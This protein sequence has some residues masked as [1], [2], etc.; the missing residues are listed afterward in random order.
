MSPTPWSASTPAV[1]VTSELAADVA[2]TNAM[3]GGSLATSTSPR[4]SKLV[5]VAPVSVPATEAALAVLRQEVGGLREDLRGVRATL[6]EELR[7]RHVNKST[8]TDGL[9]GAVAW[10]CE[11]L[12]TRE[13]EAWLLKEEVARRNSGTAAIVPM[14]KRAVTRSLSAPER[15][16][17]S[18]N[19][20]AGTAPAIWDGHV[21]DVSVGSSM[22]A[23]SE[24]GSRAAQERAA[25]TARP[26]TGSSSSRHTEPDNNL[27]YS[28][29]SKRPSWGDSPRSKSS[30]HGRKGSSNI[31]KESLG[32]SLTSNLSSRPSS[33]QS[34]RDPAMKDSRMT[35][36]RESSAVSLGTPRQAAR[37]SLHALPSGSQPGSLSSSVN[38]SSTRHLVP[39]SRGAARGPSRGASRPSSE[40]ELQLDEIDELWVRALQR[41]PAHSLV[42]EATGVYRLGHQDGI[43]VQCFS[44][45]GRLYVHAPRTPVSPHGGILDA[46]VFLASHPVVEREPLPLAIANMPEPLVLGDD[47]LRTEVAAQL[48]EMSAMSQEMAARRTENARGGKDEKRQISSRF[49][50]SINNRHSTRGAPT[51]RAVNSMDKPRK[52]P[53]NKEGS[54]RS[55]GG[56]G[57]PKFYHEPGVWSPGNGSWSP[58]RPS[59]PNANRSMW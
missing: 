59:S 6:D 8:T 56:V 55:S 22:R 36:T 20:P 25:K 11:E 30:E 31:G 58:A 54:S 5:S 26:R 49:H 52:R 10:L 17:R 34:S 32:G 4:T 33:R 23:R 47:V 12:A 21:D 9:Q 37:S 29:T 7:R 15:F 38:S 53:T 41:Y 45:H 46:E 16:L 24:H 3:H 40:S 14:G 39:S 42:K 43:R 57:K 35:A 44:N 13:R 51:A 19:N 48:K 28:W 1:L 18:A 2:G 27:L 50:S